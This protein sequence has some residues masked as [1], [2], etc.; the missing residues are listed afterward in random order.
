MQNGICKVCPKKC[1]WDSHKNL[2]FWIQ[3]TTEMVEEVLLE[4][5]EAAKAAAAGVSNTEAVL[6]KQRDKYIE[7]K[8]R[9]LNDI[10]VVRLSIERLRAIALRPEALDPDDHFQQMIDSE[11]L[12]KEPGFH[13]RIQAIQTARK[14][15]RYLR[16]IQEGKA[17]RRV[18]EMDENLIKIDHEIEVIAHKYNKTAE[19]VR[20][21][22][23]MARLWDSVRNAFDS[24]ELA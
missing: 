19:R 16:E 12:R 6:R 1:R 15:A 17:N 14:E 24:K 11:M 23:V 18:E 4:K 8:L 7:T 13:F 21:K 10:E 22:G 9:V 20:S 5:K 3:H 2:P